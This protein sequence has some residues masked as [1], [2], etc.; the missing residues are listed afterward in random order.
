MLISSVILMGKKPQQTRAVACRNFL[1]IR[2]T[3]ASLKFEE[4]T[5]YV[6]RIKF[7]LTQ[8]VVEINLRILFHVKVDK[9]VGCSKF[10]VSC[11]LEYY[12]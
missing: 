5:F 4:N 12:Q 6:L 11:A 3:R 2:F 7:I 1:V 10:V 9:I 8:V